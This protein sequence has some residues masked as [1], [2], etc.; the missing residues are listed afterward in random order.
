MKCLCTKF[1]ECFHCER[2]AKIDERLNFKKTMFMSM[3]KKKRLTLDEQDEFTNLFYEV[4][5]STFMLTLSNEDLDRCTS[6][7]NGKEEPF[8]P[9]EPKK[10]AGE[11]I[12]YAPQTTQEVE[13]R[14]ALNFL[15]VIYA[16]E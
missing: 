5:A 4:S 13:D 2:L 9:K 8:I 10:K 15:D 6:I 12:N 16:D 3:L 7:I 11:V 14:D 1:Y